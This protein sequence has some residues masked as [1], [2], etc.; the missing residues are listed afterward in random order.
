MSSSN[1]QSQLSQPE[2]DRL[3]D[4]LRA[5][6]ALP[7]VDNVRDFVWEVIFSY[8]RGIDPRADAL[9]F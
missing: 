9:N 4:G 3:E 2:L 5:A 6:M 1:E 7:F 8:M